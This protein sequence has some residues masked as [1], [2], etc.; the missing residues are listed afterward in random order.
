[1]SSNIFYNPKSA[2]A[3]A[4][5]ES[6]KLMAKNYEVFPELPLIIRKD[7]RSQKEFGD[8]ALILDAFLHIH[9]NAPTDMVA[10]WISKHDL[11]G[12]LTEPEKA[13]LNKSNA[14]LSE[15]E[16]VRVF[17]YIESLWALLWAGRRINMTAEKCS[18]GSAPWPRCSP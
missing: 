9:F 14:D 17:W 13:I 15:E 4:K 6:E 18:S 8:R 5:K 16:K 1:M 3:K 11:E 7:M 10:E 2:A 12:A